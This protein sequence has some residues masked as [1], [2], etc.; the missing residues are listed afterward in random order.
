[1]HSLVLVML[2][3]LHSEDRASSQLTQEEQKTFYE[4][5]L[6]PA[7]ERLTQTT[8]SEWPATYSDELFRARGSNGQLSFCSKVVGEW[9]LPDLG[10]AI[11]E[12]LDENGCKWGKGL[13]FLHQ[14]RGVKHS[15]PHGMQE[16]EASDALHAFLEMYNLT[17]ILEDVT[18]K[19]RLDIG[20]EFR[21]S[22]D[23]CFGWRSDS[24]NH[25]ARRALSIS[26]NAATRITRPGSSLYNRDLVSHLAA[27]SGC[28]ITPGIAHGPQ[29]VTYMQLY[30]TD[31]ALIYR[32]DGTAHGKNITGKEILAGKGPKFI[33]NL[34][35]LYNN[36]IHTCRAHARIEVRVPL[37]EADTV[38]LNLD[39][40]LIR[41]SLVSVHPN[42]WWSVTYLFN[43]YSR[44][45]TSPQVLT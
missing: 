42:V 19:W 4:K 15:S 9:L 26:E 20:I 43:L 34:V 22:F 21:S 12:A 44:L 32:P 7:I 13:V 29:D 16:G 23:N 28:R 10:N 36:A 2:P 18:G 37:A 5:G 38:L 14:L 1:V 27:V 6:R 25:V 11:R 45:F 35:Q 33:E 40:E 31:K 39:E 30:T 8:A 17:S 24:H 3:D 41:G